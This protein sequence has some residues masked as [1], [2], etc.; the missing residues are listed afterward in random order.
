MHRFESK[1]WLKIKVVIDKDK[2]G[3]KQEDNSK[4]KAVFI[5][6]ISGDKA[7]HLLA[8]GFCLILEDSIQI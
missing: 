4:Q 8:S 1:D 3:K 7:L 2:R 6:R 5:D